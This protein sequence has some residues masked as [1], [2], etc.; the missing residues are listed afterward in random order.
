[1]FIVSKINQLISIVGIIFQS[2]NYLQKIPTFVNL[3]M[4]CQCWSSIFFWRLKCYDNLKSYI[5]LFLVII[6]FSLWRLGFEGLISGLENRRDRPFCYLFSSRKGHH[7][8]FD[9]K[10]LRAY[11]Q[12]HRIKLFISARTK[13]HLFCS[14]NRKS[15]GRSDLSNYF[16]A[17]TWLNTSF[18]THVGLSSSSS[19]AFKNRHPFP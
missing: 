13:D 17:R 2:T 6:S 18:L 5:L 12:I 14:K 15:W 4:I 9:L 8:L 16:Y 19:C 1:M 7:D 3:L 11:V 10:M